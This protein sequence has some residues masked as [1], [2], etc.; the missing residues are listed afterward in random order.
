MAWSSCAGANGGWYASLTRCVHFGRPP[1]A[2]RRKMEAVATIVTVF[3]SSTCPGRTLGS[4][5]ADAQVACAQAGFPDDWKMH[6]QGGSSRYE[7][8]EL[9]AVSGMVKDIVAGQ[10]FA[11]NPSIQGAK[12]EETIPVGPD[13]NEILTSIVGWPTIPIVVNG[14]EYLRPGIHEVM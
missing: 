9:V 11:W 8:R 1:E 6:R 4:V 14:R 13:N 10:A 12:S 5:F 3:I 7:P 2:L